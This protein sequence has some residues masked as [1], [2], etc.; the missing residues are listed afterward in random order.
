M[1]QSSHVHFDLKPS[2]HSYEL[3]EDES[4][5]YSRQVLQESMD[6]DRGERAFLQTHPKTQLDITLRVFDECR[7]HDTT[8][9]FGNLGRHP[10]LLT[11]FL[12]Y[13][14][15]ARESVGVVSEWN[16]D[17]PYQV[18]TPPPVLDF[19]FLIEP[20]F[21]CSVLKPHNVHHLVVLTSHLV[22]DL[23]TCHM[24]QLHLAPPVDPTPFCS[25]SWKAINPPVFHDGRVNHLPPKVRVHLDVTDAKSAHEAYLRVL[26]GR[27][28]AGNRL[29]T[30]Q[31]S[32]RD[33]RRIHKNIEKLR[34]KVCSLGW[35]EEWIA[36]VYLNFFK[37][38]V[39]PFTILQRPSN[40]AEPESVWFVSHGDRR[41]EGD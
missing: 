16:T 35:Q 34:E 37:N 25:Q 32:P 2:H 31:L 33:H 21:G 4:I 39:H 3:S 9:V 6:R 27:E 1:E 12:D 23:P 38:T 28:L 26:T 36:D 29:T 19:L 41:P 40:N 30:V 8:V 13:G 22:L 7:Q 10:L 15:T 5:G 11:Y 17:S 20:Y 24:T 14:F 18:E